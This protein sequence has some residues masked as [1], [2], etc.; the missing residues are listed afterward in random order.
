MP[1]KLTQAV[2]IG[3]DVDD[4]W[5]AE[6]QLPYCLTDGIDSLCRKVGKKNYHFRC[7][8]FHKSADLIY[9]ATKV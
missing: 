4:A 6:N 8:K 7:V 2:C 9:T 1:A 3:N 5:F